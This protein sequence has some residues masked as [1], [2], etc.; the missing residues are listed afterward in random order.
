MLLAYP[1]TFNEAQ[2]EQYLQHP[3]GLDAAYCCLSQPLALRRL[4]GLH[5]PEA[6]ANKPRRFEK[7]D[8]RR[9][10][11]IA[12]VSGRAD[13][14]DIQ[15]GTEPVEVACVEGGIQVSNG[16]RL[17]AQP[18]QD[19][20]QLTKSLLHFGDGFLWLHHFSLSATCLNSA[21]DHPQLL[22]IRARVHNQLVNS[23]SA[24]SLNPRN[25]VASGWARPH[26]VGILRH[27]IVTRASRKS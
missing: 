2:L 8:E 26:N 25:L 16:L 9:H 24:Q 13:A 12:L 14:A 17:I 11:G 21:R 3:F 18:L 5:L 27:E 4:Q 20:H 10:V 23:T 7:Y 15:S 1:M 6:A 19:L 22:F